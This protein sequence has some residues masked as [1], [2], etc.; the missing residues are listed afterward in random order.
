ML[1]K[2]GLEPGVRGYVASVLYAR[3][4]DV[5]AHHPGGGVS[6]RSAG[7]P[8]AFGPDLGHTPLNPERR[9]QIE[10]HI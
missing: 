6:S 8:P 10:Y 7:A 5:H 2:F 4:S 3:P 1:G 9:V